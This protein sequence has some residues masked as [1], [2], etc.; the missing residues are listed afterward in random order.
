MRIIIGV[1]LIFSL[2]FNSIASGESSD[3]TDL[4]GDDMEIIQNL[5]LLENLEMLENVDLLENYEA[6]EDI[7]ALEAKGE[8]NEQE[9]N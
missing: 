2:S 5:E 8:V 1:L 7:Q 4:S 3:S 6:V 9:D